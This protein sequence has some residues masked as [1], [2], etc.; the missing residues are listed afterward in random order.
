MIL[1]LFLVFD[2]AICSVQA[3]LDLGIEKHLYSNKENFGLEEVEVEVEGLILL[4]EPFAHMTG[5]SVCE[6]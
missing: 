2:Q 4:G 3:W 5:I 6:F 1:L